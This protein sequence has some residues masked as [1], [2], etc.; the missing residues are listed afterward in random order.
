MRSFVATTPDL[1]TLAQGDKETALQDVKPADAQKVFES[2]KGKA[3]EFPG[4]TVVSATD[5]QMVL[6]VSDDAV[7][8]KTPDFTVN[9]KEPLK[10]IPQPGEKLTVGGTY[11][12]YT[13]SPL[14]ITLSGGYLVAPKKAAPPV[15]H[16]VHHS[17]M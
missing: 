4:V 6:E 5:S 9:M 8:S 3:D 16:T 17:G 11:D 15:H 14:M 2:V 13:A 10:T 12:S 7:A 1:A